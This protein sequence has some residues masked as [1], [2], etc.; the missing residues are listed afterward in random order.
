MPGT[1]AK[2]NEVQALMGSMVLRHLGEVIRRRAAITD[3]YRSRLKGVP[4]IRLSPPLPPDVEFNHAYMP[5]EVDEEEFGMGRNALHGKL[6]EYNVYCRRYFYP[7]IC[8][9]ACYSSLSVKDPLTVA[10]RVT[11]RILTLPIYDT[12]EP[13]EAEIICDLIVS[14]QLP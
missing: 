9:Y 7:L 12:L 3:V 11:E 4:G 2:M 14:F 10:R 13:S 1:N 6:K 5:V 8:D